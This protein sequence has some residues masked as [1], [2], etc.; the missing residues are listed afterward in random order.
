MTPPTTPPT[1]P[2]RRRH[3]ATD[4][5]AQRRPALRPARL[6][7]GSSKQL[8]F[9]HYFTPFPISLDNKDPSVDYYARNYLHAS[10]RVGQARRVRRTAARPPDRSGAVERGLPAARTSRPRSGRPAPPGWTAS[11]S[12]SCRSRAANWDRVKL[13]LDAAHRRRPVVQDHAHAGHDHAG[14]PDARR[15]WPRPCRHARQATRPPSTWPTV[16]W[17]S[18]RSRR[19]PRPPA[20]W[21]SWLNLMKTSHATTVAFVPTLLDLQQYADAVRADQLRPVGVGP[22]LAGDE[23]ERGQARRAG[24]RARQDLHGPGQGPGRAPRSRASTRRPA[25]PRPCG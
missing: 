22:E 13:L 19:R 25:T 8:A 23:P 4:D 12:T 18:R 10:R 16:A 5:A 11:P 24:A 3:D 21:A 14:R 1:T 6:G 17:S 15:R 9:A 20:W 7:L 2:P